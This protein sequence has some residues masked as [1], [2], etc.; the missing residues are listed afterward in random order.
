MPTVVLVGAEYEENLSL[1]YLA[2]SVERVGFRAEIVPF[3]SASGLEE[4]VRRTLS[5][6]P[7]VVGISVPFQLRAFELLSFAS[8]LRSSGFSGHICVGGQPLS[9][10]A[11]FSATF[12]QGVE[13]FCRGGRL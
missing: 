4:A 1:R 11:T 9:N 2:A 5:A 10:I 6:R 3:N 8:H 12:L 7:V 13:Q